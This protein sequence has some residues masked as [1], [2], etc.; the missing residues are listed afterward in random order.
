METGIRL[1]H[2]AKRTYI[3][4]TMNRM[5]P[6]ISLLAGLLL[7]LALAANATNLQRSD[8]AAE[9]AWVLHLDLDGLRPT[10]I[11]QYIMSE[12][13][14]PDAQAQ[15]AAFQSIFNLDPRKQLHGLTLYSTGSAPQDGVLLLYADFDTDRLETLA[16]AAKDYQPT[17]H[18]QH[19]IHSWVET[20][21]HHDDS[22]KVARTYASMHNGKIIVFGQRE[23]RVSAALDVLDRSAPNLS[24]SSSFPQLGANRDGSFLQAA[25]RKL[26]IPSTDPS[27]AFFKLAKTARVQLGET[28]Q[29]LTLTAHLE[30]NDDEVAKYMTSIGQ[31][32]LALAKM[33]TEKPD[34][35][36]LASAVTLKQQGT[37]VLATLQLPA[38]DII[39]MMKADTARKEKHRKDKE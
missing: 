17:T 32:L 25:A 9:P 5:N 2:M 39:E 30:A 34:G 16:R 3:I 21:K 6:K 24:N 27:A 10:V 26:E 18:N 31:G 33:Q 35:V 23:S 4:E 14:K 7:G 38:S 12:L 8:V 19:T 15:I 28:R 22:G 11:G 37:E 29:Q 36:K 13:E 20:K 1:L